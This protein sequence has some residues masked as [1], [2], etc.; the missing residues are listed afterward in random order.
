MWPMLTLCSVPGRACLPVLGSGTLCDL[1]AGRLHFWT[2]ASQSVLNPSLLILLQV[3]Q[4]LQSGPGLC[5]CSPK[6]W[7]NLTEGVTLPLWQL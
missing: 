2:M 6:A 3:P 5:N 7:P 1:R 4:L